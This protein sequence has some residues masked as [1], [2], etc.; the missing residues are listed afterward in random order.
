MQ[1][2][3]IPQ[4]APYF[5]AVVCYCFIGNRHDMLILKRRN[6]DPYYSGLWGFPAGKKEQ[7]ERTFAEAAVREINEET[8]NL[9][10][11]NNLRVL[12][13]LAFKHF[14]PKDEYFYFLARSFVVD[15]VLPRF[16]RNP[17]EHIAAMIV[18]AEEILGMKSKYFIPDALKLFA[19]HYHE[20][21]IPP[22]IGETIFHAAPRI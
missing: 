7:G 14:K 8:G 20:L 19:S 3:G 2:E 4:N 10:S 9:V 22:S 16:R 15:L 11:V 17:A 18:P 21:L 12:D 1:I 5:E 13:T 6:D